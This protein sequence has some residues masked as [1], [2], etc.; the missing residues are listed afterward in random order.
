MKPLCI[1]SLLLFGI[2][3][4]QESRSSPNTKIFTGNNLLDTGIGFLGGLGAGFVGSNFLASLANSNNGGNNCGRRKRKAPG[5]NQPV[6]IAIVYA[7][8]I[9]PFKTSMAIPM[10][11]AERQIRPG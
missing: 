1:V 8:T 2:S 11:L 5:E 7:T 9:S 4:A 10:G 3:V 6:T